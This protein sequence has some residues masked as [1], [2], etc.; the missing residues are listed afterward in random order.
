MCTC[1]C[2]RAVSASIHGGLYIWRPLYMAAPTSIK[3]TV[4]VILV[5][6]YA[7]T[8]GCLNP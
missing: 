7:S 1:V 2:V 4:L 5:E 3:L 8:F 6:V